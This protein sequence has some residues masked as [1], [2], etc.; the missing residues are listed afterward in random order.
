MAIS[1]CPNDTFIFDALI[2]SKIDT[3]GFE[4]ETVLDDIQRLNE[5]ARRKE[6]DLIKV[7]AGVIPFIWEDYF[8]LPSGGAIGYGVGPLLIT[9]P[10]RKL[11]EPS[12]NNTTIALPGFNTTAHFLFSMAYPSAVNKKFISFA[13]IEEEVGNGLA[14]YGVIIHE[15]RFTYQQKGLHLVKD[16][17]T[18]WQEQT[19]SPIP[20]GVI[21]AKRTLPLNILHTLNRLIRKSLEY[22]EATSLPDLPQFVC[23][24]AQEMSTEVMREHIRLYV[25]AFS[26]DM[27]EQ[28]KHAIFQMLKIQGGALDHPQKIP[29]DLFL[30]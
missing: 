5:L 16:L 8:I 18:Y 6:M 24:H 7:S 14:D 15:N 29:E 4:F 26:R 10:E 17:G 28:G 21:A 19:G 13:D 30:P 25:N 2:N 11:T 20:L 12:G 22:A 27:G 1:P 3:E 23:M 9:R